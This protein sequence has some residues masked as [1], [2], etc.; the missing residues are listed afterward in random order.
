MLS[1]GK[2]TWHG[3]KALQPDWSDWSHSIALSAELPNERI[4]C[5]LALN[6]HCE[7][8]EFE[9]PKLSASRAWHRW[10][11]TVRDS[12]QDIVDWKSAP[13]I[14]CDKYLVQPHSVLMLTTD[15]HES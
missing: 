12:P 13:T 7:P 4:Q 11:D 1:R 15:M 6:A 10:I 9:L 2:I 14:D 5:Y 3:V 8:L